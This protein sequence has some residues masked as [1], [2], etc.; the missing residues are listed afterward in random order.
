MAIFGRKSLL[1]QIEQTQVLDTTAPFL[2]NNLQDY[3]NSLH[4]EMLS[5]LG[6][7]N[8]ANDK[9]ER[10]I[11][12]EVNANNQYINVNI[13]L[14]LELREEA[15][16]AINEMFGTSITVERGVEPNKEVLSDANIPG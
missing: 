5:L 10:L 16:K 13:D 12:D 8:S 7:N 2:L 1:N 3:K 15:A 14:M 9:K 6:I 11:T 4:S